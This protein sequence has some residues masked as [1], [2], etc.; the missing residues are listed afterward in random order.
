MKK[1]TRVYANKYDKIAGSK[2]SWADWIPAHKVGA[3]KVLFD[4]I[5]ASVG[6]YRGA[7]EFIGL[8]GSSI[9]AFEKGKISALNGRRI[10]EAYQRI[11]EKA[12][13]LETL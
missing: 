8:S 12:N 1:Q 3:F 9:D 4:K 11:Q 10:L 7:K 5:R 13:D 2:G 6:T